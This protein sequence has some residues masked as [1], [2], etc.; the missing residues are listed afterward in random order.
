[1]QSARK[2]FGQNAEMIELMKDLVAIS[3]PYFQE[4]EVMR[5]AHGWLK[6]QGFDPLFHKYSESKVF[7]Y[8]GEN[9]VCTAAGQSAGPTVCLNG[10]LDTVTLTKGWSRDPYA[11]LIED[12]RMY[13][14]GA[15]DMKSG[16]CAMMLAMRNF[17]KK[18]PKFSGRIILTL[19][20][21]EEGPFGLGTNALIEDGTLEGVDCSIVTEPSA[22]FTKQDFPTLALGARGSF[23]YQVEF[24]GKAAHAAMPE[25][26]INAAV[27]AGK[28][29]GAL[30]RITPREDPLLGGGRVCPISMEADGGA[31]SV[32]EYAKVTVQRHI[33]TGDEV[34]AVLGE[35][36]ELLDSLNLKSRY[37]LGL[38]DYPSEPT[39]LY[40]P[41]TVP[42]ENPHAAAMIE[43]MRQ[44][45]GREPNYGYLATIGDFNYLGTRLGGAPALLVGAAGENIHQSDEFV[46]LSS[47]SGLIEVLED[48]LVRTLVR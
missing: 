4:A 31:C 45:C 40:Q 33:V 35:V 3:S 9:V 47:I 26:G 5:Y 17:V 7:K 20:S 46:L 18:N 37:K 30:K 13:G 29:L 15:L 19:V 42:R 36:R 39:R 38:R 24:F 6:E 34:E 25:D 22:G 43:S 10:H 1:M 12:D 23:V 8:D 27:D 28:F 2:N 16:C 48:F 44:V 41:Y 14:L 11:G 21:D 32:P